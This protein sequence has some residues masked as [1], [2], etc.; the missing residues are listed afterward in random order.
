MDEYDPLSEYNKIPFSHN[1]TDGA[2]TSK[3]TSKL[4]S[5][6]H[7]RYSIVIPCFVPRINTVH[8]NNHY[9]HGFRNTFDHN[10]FIN[11]D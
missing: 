9:N 8:L 11:S 6:M 7:F 3:S 5:A 1:R 4:R 2:V 10:H